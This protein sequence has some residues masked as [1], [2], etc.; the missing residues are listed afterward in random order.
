[1]KWIVTVPL[2]VEAADM[3]KEQVIEYLVQQRVINGP[4]D[5]C[6]VEQVEEVQLAAAQELENEVRD[7]QQNFEPCEDQNE[8]QK[9][10][11]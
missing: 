6:S 7:E 3:T 10:E 5:V 8:P 9:L 4:A 1:M 2:V 11:L